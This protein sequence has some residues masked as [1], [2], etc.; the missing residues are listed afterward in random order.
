MTQSLHSNK[1]F[2]TRPAPAVDARAGVL[3]RRSVT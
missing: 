2:Q 1:L 3:V